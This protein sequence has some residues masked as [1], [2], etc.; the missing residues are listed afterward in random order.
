MGLAMSRLSSRAGIKEPEIGNSGGGVLPPVEYGGG[1]DGRGGDESPDYG[2][3]LRRARF[4]L[5]LAIAP[6]LMM[7]VTFTGAYV[8]R[9]QTTTFNLETNTRVREWMHVSLPVTLLLVNTFLLIASTFTIEMARRQTMRD[10]VLAPV[11]SIPG[12]SLGKE[13]RVPWLGFTAMLG[14]GFLAG[15]WMAWRV[16]ASR[17]FH[18]PTSASSSFVYLLTAAHGVHLVLGLT[19]LF[20]AL[21]ISVLHKPLETRHI[22][23]D[24]TSWYWHFM[25]LLW[26]Y[27]F[28]LLK[29]TS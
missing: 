3:R 24:I 20:Y 6:I 21:A 14:V 22:A 26:L 29:F 10:I 19:A 8:A 12:V 16:L 11:R 9:Q 5:A 25:T 28:A 13:H 4:G 1:G 15:Q 2:Q 27:I 7:F 18:L 17:G 23:I